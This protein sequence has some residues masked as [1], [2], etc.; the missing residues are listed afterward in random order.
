MHPEGIF[1]AWYASYACLCRPSQH[2]SDVWAIGCMPAEGRK[3]D[4]DISCWVCLGGFRHAPLQGDGDLLPAKE[5]L[6]KAPWI[7]R[8]HY[9]GH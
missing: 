2:A 5:H 4:E 7:A 9:T 1:A 8:L 6:L 3:V